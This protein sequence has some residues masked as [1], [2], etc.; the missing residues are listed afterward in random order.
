VHLGDDDGGS[1]L[2][3]SITAEI[4]SAY[5]G[6]LELGRAELGGLSVRLS[7]PLRG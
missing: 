4:L 1:G 2:G 3:L 6:S 5:G 7:V